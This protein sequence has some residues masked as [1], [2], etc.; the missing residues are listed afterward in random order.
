MKKTWKKIIISAIS[1]CLVAVCALGLIACGGGS[2][3]KSSAVKKFYDANGARAGSVT[4]NGGFVAEDEKYYYVINGVGDSTAK[5]SFGAPVKGSLIAVSKADVTKSQI[6]VPKLF[7]ASDYGAGVYIYGDYV[8][9]G[10]PSTD[11][12]SSGDIDN[13]K[14][15]F[16]KT[17]LDGTGTK[18][19]FTVDSLSNEYRFVEIGGEV[20]LLYYDADDTALVSYNTAKKKSAE[21]IVTSDEI[22]ESLG[23]YKFLSD[24]TIVYTVTVYE[25]DY[26]ENYDRQTA[27]YNKIY[28]YK[29]GTSTEIISG[30]D[31]VIHKTFTISAVNG[32]KVFYTSTDGTSS[33]ITKTY[34]FDTANLAV[35]PVEVKNTAYAVA[36][37]LIVGEDVYMKD[38]NGNKL[39]KSSL[40]GDDNLKEYVAEAETFGKLLFLK[41]DYI[42]YINSNSKIARIFVGTLPALGATDY[43]EKISEQLVS[44]DTVLTSWYAPELIGNV[45]FYVDDSA[46]GLS[47]VKCI[48]LS[49]ATLETETDDDGEITSYYLE[50]SVLVG[51][52]NEEDEESFKNTQ[53]E[54]KINEL[55]SKI[56]YDKDDD[57]NVILTEGKP[58]FNDAKAIIA[59]ARALYETAVKAGVSISDNTL[60]VIEKYEYVVILSEKLVALYEFDTV[61]DA[62][63]ANF[64]D[65]YETAKKAIESLK[66]SKVYDESD[67]DGMLAVNLRYYYQEADEHFNPD[68]AE[69]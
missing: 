37:A 21:I 43:E 51:K 26:N 48:D 10:S 32:S 53:I 67:I 63:K 33:P 28:A 65:A 40:T 24:G 44:E 59:E 19:F 4:G 20:C 58:T 61:S 41:G 22:T 3:W 34:V 68:T 9:Y 69:A 30:D 15:T 12:N 56:D 29:N 13:E 27:D 46:L 7:V 2:S 57:G 16:A 49:T 11:K 66:S 42:Y 45:I 8:Y 31:S 39:V 50:G 54:N 14:M 17:K 64:K 6:I 1:L 52:M 35:A 36:D 23:D 60:D 25:G 47:Y 18:T 5:N 55:N 38:S 62:N